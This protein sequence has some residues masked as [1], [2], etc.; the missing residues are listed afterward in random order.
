VSET[1]PAAIP[2]DIDFDPAKSFTVVAAAPAPAPEVTLRAL[3]TGCAIGAV[4]AAGNVYTSLKIGIIDGG[5]ITAALLGFSLFATFK[6]LGRTPYG[7]LE[8]N[9]TQTVASSAAVMTFSTGLVGPI[10][11]LGLMG[12]R[13]PGWAIAL[14]GVAVT[15]LGILMA[16]L[17]RRRLIVEESLPFPTGKATGAILETIHT[18]R[19]TAKTPTI[20]LIAAAVVAAVVTCLRDGLGVIPE[21]TVFPGMV[22]GFAAATLTIGIGWSP[23]MVSTGAML[24]LRG[25]GS[26]LLGAAI[27]RV[28]LAPWIAGKGVVASPD[29]THAT[30]WLVWPALGLLVAGSFMPLLLGGGAILRS[31]RDVIFLRRSAPRREAAAPSGASLGPRTWAPLLG[32]ALIVIFALGWRVFDLHPTGMAIGLVLSLFLTVVTARSTGETDMAPGGATGTISQLA[33]GNRGPTGSIVGGSLSLATTSMAAQMLWAYKAGHRFGASPRAQLIAQMVG[34]TVGAVVSVPIYAVILATYALGTERM[35]AS[36]ALSWRA[37]ADAIQGG[38]TALPPYGIKAAL[39]AL[40]LGIALTLLART[41]V[42]NWVPAPAAMGV[43]VLVP[44][45][46]SVAIMAGAVIVEI[47]RRVRPDLDERAVMAAAA[48]GLAGEALTGVLI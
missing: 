12:F 47:V 48:G 46:L 7:V 15:S 20:L 39:V 36:S 3:L 16:T 25:A 11:A 10:P 41:Q 43:A 5:S 45:W 33:L 38:L 4:L 6:R 14:W 1:A 17:L 31:F 19:K 22:A 8:N 32:A 21:Q 28:G 23:L 18:A 35:P 27:A 34:A 30:S 29:F 44:L 2:S 13:Y 37:T 42:R 24:G 26:M 40:G 9:I